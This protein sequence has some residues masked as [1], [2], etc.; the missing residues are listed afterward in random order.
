MCKKFLLLVSF[1]KNGTSLLVLYEYYIHGNIHVCTSIQDGVTALIVAAQ[2]NRS[3]VIKELLRGGANCNLQ[4]KVIFN[5]QVHCICDI[6][7][8][9]KVW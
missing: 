1:C 5:I 6:F 2:F 4:D 9:K 8:L 3:D 7:A